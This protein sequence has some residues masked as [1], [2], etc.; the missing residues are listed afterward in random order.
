MTEII[1]SMTNRECAMDLILVAFLLIIDH[2]NV[3][4]CWVCLVGRI[5]DIVSVWIISDSGTHP[6]RKYQ[7]FVH[8]IYNKVFWIYLFIMHWSIFIFSIPKLYIYSIFLLDVCTPVL[9][10]FMYLLFLGNV[11]VSIYYSI[12]RFPFYVIII[13]HHNTKWKIGLEHCT[14]LVHVQAGPKLHSPA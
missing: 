7:H 8:C 13:L 5:E 10:L 14:S 2:E 1:T 4:E 9:L 6:R 3:I 12:I 11:I